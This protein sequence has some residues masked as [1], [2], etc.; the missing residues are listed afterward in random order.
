MESLIA[1]IL[2]PENIADVIKV[3]AAL[4]AKDFLSNLFRRLAKRF[5]NDKDPKNDGMA[6]VLESAA[7]TLEKVRLPVRK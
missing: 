1:N 7:E 6:D 4:F 2:T 3:I 5:R